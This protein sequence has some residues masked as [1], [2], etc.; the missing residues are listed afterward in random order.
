MARIVSVVWLAM[1][2]AAYAATDLGITNYSFVDP[3]ARGALR[4]SHPPFT[5]SARTSPSSAALARICHNN[6]THQRG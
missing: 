4:N 1:P 3:A 5:N 6:G 2:V